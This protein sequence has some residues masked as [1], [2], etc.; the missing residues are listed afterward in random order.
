MICIEVSV[1]GKVVSLAGIGDSGLLAT[2]LVVVQRPSEEESAADSGRVSH[3]HLFVSGVTEGKHFRWPE[4]NETKLEIGDE[5]AFR[6]VE[7]DTPDRGVR[8]Y[9]KPKS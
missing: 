1:N 8:H 7:S 6:I 3:M 5:V 2:N 4:P 9:P